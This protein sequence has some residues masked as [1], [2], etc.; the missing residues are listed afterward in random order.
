MIEYGFIGNQNASNT[1]T[2]MTFVTE[3]LRQ[4]PREVLRVLNQAKSCLMASCLLA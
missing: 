1:N 2:A 4:L 3:S